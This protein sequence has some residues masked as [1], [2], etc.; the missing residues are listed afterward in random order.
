MRFIENRVYECAKLLP[1]LPNLNP[2]EQFWPV[3]K[4]K[5]KREKLLESEILDVK[6]SLLAT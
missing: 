3:V 6:M 5:S 2:I 1:Y 4:I